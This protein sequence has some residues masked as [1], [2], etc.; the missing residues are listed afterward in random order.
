[1]NYG[2]LVNV[3]KMVIHYCKHSEW[4]DWRVIYFSCGH[5]TVVRDHSNKG[6]RQ[7]RL[8]RMIDHD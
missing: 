7:C 4:P 2:Q 8:C 5:G 6:R 1:M 3:V